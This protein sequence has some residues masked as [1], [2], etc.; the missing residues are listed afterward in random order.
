MDEDEEFKTK[1]NQSTDKKGLPSIQKK[2]TNQFFKLDDIDSADKMKRND[3]N[4]GSPIHHIA[5]DKTKENHMRNTSDKLKEIEDVVSHPNGT[6]SGS[7]HK[8]FAKHSGRKSILKHDETPN[9]HDK[10]MPHTD[11]QEN[12]GA[13]NEVMYKE[14]RK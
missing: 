3:S 9:S 13:V 12:E 5:V 10:S 8:L 6:V 11:K 4:V 1:D 14:R 7:D 2:K